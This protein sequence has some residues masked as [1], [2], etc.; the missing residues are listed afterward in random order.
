MAIAGLT[1]RSL[2]YLREQANGK[3]ERKLKDNTTRV[4]EHPLYKAGLI[5]GR[6]VEVFQTT[7]ESASIPRRGRGTTK[8][9]V[10]TS[11]ETWTWN[12]NVATWWE[13]N[14]FVSA[15]PCSQPVH[16]P[17]VSQPLLTVAVSQPLATSHL[18]QEVIKA[19]NCMLCFRITSE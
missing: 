16:V 1:R 18:I 13:P 10:L 12:S 4:G 3:N 15:F 19:H 7:P 6:L 9:R 8:A 11:Q 14:H 5:P 2:I 17:T